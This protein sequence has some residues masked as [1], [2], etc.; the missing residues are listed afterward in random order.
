MP[1]DILGLALHR[2]GS[3]R[4]DEPCAPPSCNCCSTSVGRARPSRPA[5]RPRTPSRSQ[6]RPATNSFARATVSSR[7]ATSACT[8]S[9][10]SAT[11]PRSAIRWTNLRIQR[12]AAGPLEQG[13][14]RLRR[15]HRTMQQGCDQLGRFLVGER[16]EVDR[17]RVA[18][19]RRPGRVLVVPAGA[20]GTEQEQRHS[21]SPVG[22]VLEEGHERRIRPVQVLEHEYRRPFCCQRLEEVAPGLE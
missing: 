19:T 15:Q 22:Q 13:L 11:S 6:K 3:G 21:S 8:E 9:G 4:A 2:A 20:G 1:E 10:T 14:E 17:R 7:A 12:V 5:R 18:Q 16:G